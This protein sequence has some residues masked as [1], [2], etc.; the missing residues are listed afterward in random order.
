LKEK[1]NAAVKGKIALAFTSI[2]IAFSGCSSY[3]A[4][5]TA[6]KDGQQILTEQGSTEQGNNKDKN[7]NAIYSSIFAQQAIKSSVD[8]A[9]QWQLNHMTDMEHYIRRINEKTADP[10]GWV[11]GTF[12]HGATQWAEQSGNNTLFKSLK[13][14]LAQSDWKL[15]KRLYHAD[16]HVI[17]QSYL[18]L[19][20]HYQDE[21]MIK[22]LITD[23]N[24][25][26][27]EPPALSHLSFTPKG[28]LKAQG[29][30]HDC[31]RRWCWADAL[32]MSPP[33]WMR[34]S[35]LTGDK[36]YQNYAVQEYKAS[37][38]V[39][40]D[41]SENLFLRDDRYKTKQ[42]LHGEKVLWARGN[43]WV[44]SGLTSIIDALDK[45]DADRAWFVA[46]YKKMA[47]RLITLQ[48]KSGSWP[49]SLLAGQ[50]YLEKETSGSAFFTAGLAWGLNNHILD[51]TTYLPSVK[52]AWAALESS[53]AENG[54]VGW[55]QQIGA[56]PGK[57]EAQQ[58]QFYG[59]GAF[60]LAGKEMYRLAKNNKLD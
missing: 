56:A 5:E 22:N 60:I 52:L 25:I 45:S 31:Q 24:A 38:E 33:V 11:Q 36:K 54:M 12:L 7:T 10:I 9:T 19:F 41:K 2:V 47:A 32:F 28:K 3:V 15:S 37:Y 46:L 51:E 29:Y 44:F 26:L 42:G 30:T 13:H 34:L 20:E 49:M 6:S 53:Q 55:V 39:L 23:F 27:R 59:A 4:S 35:R 16:D 40:F 8:N 17:A 58:T 43:G 14:H 21:K 48:S 57:V 1:K 18:T 50:Y